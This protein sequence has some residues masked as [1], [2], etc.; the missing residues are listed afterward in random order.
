MIE[1]NKFKL[2]KLVVQQIAYLAGSELVVDQLI[3]ETG[4]ASIISVANTRVAQGIGAGVYSAKIGMAAMD[5]CRP[6]IYG[7]NEK[8]KLSVIVKPMYTY[9]TKL[10]VIKA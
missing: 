5:I 8:P 1:F 10:F 7:K 3:K 6:V 9:L 2:L 4:A